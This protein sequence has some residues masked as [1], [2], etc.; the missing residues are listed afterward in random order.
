MRAAL[1]TDTEIER[2]IEEARQ[3]GPG[4]TKRDI[5]VAALEE[6]VAQRKRLGVL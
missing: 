4:E 2:L 6:Y 1:R 5:V 3:L